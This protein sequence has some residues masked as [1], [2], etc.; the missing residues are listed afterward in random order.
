MNGE[1]IAGAGR[2]LTVDGAGTTEIVAA[3]QTGTGSLTKSGSGVLV[4]SSTNN[5]YTGG[6]TI[7]GG[8]LTGEISSLKGDIRDNATLAFGEPGTRS[9][10]GNI[11]GTGEVIKH[12]GGTLTLTGANSFTG[13]MHVF[14]GTLIGNT[15]S[16][17]GNI[18]NDATV[19][20]DQQPAGTY[21][22]NMAG[23]GTLI[24]QGA[25]TLRLSGINSFTG[26]TAVLQG[27]LVGNSAS[28]PGNILND[29]AVIFDQGS[30]GTYA[31]NMTGVGAFVKDGGG[32][33]SLNGINT[34]TGGT[35]VLAGTLVGNTGSLPGNIVNEAAVVF[36]QPQAGTYAGDM[37]GRGSFAKQGGGTLALTGSN[38][39]TGGTS[40]LDGALVGN[41]SSLPGN[42]VNDAVVV[43]DQARAGTYAGSMSG[44][45]TFIK[46]G[47]GALTL[48]GLNTFSG[49]TAVLD[50]TLI[51]NTTSL[52]GDILNNAAV[53]FDQA[54]AG[55][56]TGSIGGTGALMF[57]GGGSFN[58]TG[59]SGG[60]LGT[61][62]VSGA[63]LS[64][65][66]WLGGSSLVV[67]QGGTLGGNGI[68]PAVTMQAGSTLAPGNSI[69]S[70]VVNGDASFNAGSSYQ[71]ETEADGASD[72]T[73][74][75]GRLLLSGGIV[76]VHATATHRYHPINRWVIGMSNGGVVG[77][78]AGA[79]SD[80][81]YL[82]PSL[83]Y[84]A[85]NAYLTLRRNDV[86]FR[87]AGTTGTQTAVAQMFNRLVGSATGS[88][89]DTVN[90]LYDLSPAQARPAFGSM[91]GLL[92]Q[93]VA[94]NGLTSAR[95]FLGVNMRHLG[96]TD[97]NDE[98]LNPTTGHA[99]SYLTSGA[100]GSTLL[101]SPA[102][103]GKTITGSGCRASAAPP[104]TTP[105]GWNTAPTHRR[106]VWSSA[107]TPTSA[108]A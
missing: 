94:M 44:S 76:D 108:T 70:I 81:G 83:E 27:T 97:G 56:Y 25:G 5:T 24:K 107:S 80:T 69:G 64:V 96:M 63:K 51:A 3:I 31:G 67:Q 68:V 79:T 105:Q 82:V 103:R 85:R 22:G 54:R 60:F 42:I 36:D 52:P 1:T 92:Y 16:L 59:N 58:L 89:A 55:I 78:F 10:G 95:S 71:V 99:L 38:S 46:Q 34:F 37:T 41:T 88:V 77:T 2:N 7:N 91:S 102:D 57:R 14:G 90:T 21:A 87:S 12:S 20:F 48:A 15:G 13:G 43:F 53:V 45:G 49:G 6:T 23:I 104:P 106:S 62:A 4:L 101:G 19:V 98:D 50:G 65:N 30:A 93:Y 29:A 33:L 35:T 66:G 72:L 32:T 18:L 17:P 61:T 84:D 100:A 8:V 26:G 11:S 86:D 74:A 28:L 47:G 73:A 9:F 75:T 39:F 40:V